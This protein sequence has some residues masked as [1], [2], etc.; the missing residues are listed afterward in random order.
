MAVGTAAGVGA[1]CGDGDSEGV[2]QRHRQGQPAVFLVPDHD[3]AYLV[4]GGGTGEDEIGCPG[5][6]RQ[7]ARGPHEGFP[8]PRAQHPGVV[9]AAC[10]GAAEREIGG[11]SGQC[12]DG[13]VQAHGGMVT[14]RA[15]ATAAPRGVVLHHEACTGAVAGKRLVNVIIHKM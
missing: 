9:A 7:H 12:G 5:H 10:A 2:A 15:D 11:R 1:Q 8:A 6:V 14:H 4:I 3:R 13:G